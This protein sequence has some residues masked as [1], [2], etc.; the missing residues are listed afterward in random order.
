MK[1]IIILI[2]LVIISN[3]CFGQEFN[4]REGTSTAKPHDNILRCDFCNQD[5]QVF[6]SKGCMPHIIKIE[7]DQGT[8]RTCWTSL[9]TA[10][11]PIVSGT[12]S[13]K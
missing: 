2:S 11:K 12:W 5:Y 10:L 3:I 9:I 8:F 1:K 6:S 13:A 4:I 7:T